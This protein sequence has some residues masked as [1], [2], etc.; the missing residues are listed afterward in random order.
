MKTD[1]FLGCIVDENRRNILKFLD[2]KEKCVCDI[3]KGLGLEQS[4]VS[5]HLKKLKQCGL[6]KSR[7]D[8]KNIYYKISNKKI[9]N[10]LDKIQEISLE[11]K[12]NAEC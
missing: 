1:S 5:H 3:T 9:K 4:L 7:Q 12:N 8:G 2:T 11:L 10:I 6:V